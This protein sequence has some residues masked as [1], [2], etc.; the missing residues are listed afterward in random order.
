[1][2]EKKSEDG[3]RKTEDGSQ[4]T[5]VRRQKTGG[6]ESWLRIRNLASVPE[7]VEGRT[8]GIGIQ[9]SAIKGS[10]NDPTPQWQLPDYSGSVKVDPN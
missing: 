8:P 4:K 1:M 9:P 6:F 5:E 2:Y 3:R 10:R 7:P